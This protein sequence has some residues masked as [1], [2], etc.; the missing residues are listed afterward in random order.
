MLLT[1][2]ASVFQAHSAQL[3]QSAHNN[4]DA[5]YF[6][7]RL[8]RAVSNVKK[9]TSTSVII[10][11]NRKLRGLFAERLDTQTDPRKQTRPK[12]DSDPTHLQ[13]QRVFLY[14][15]PVVWLLA[16]ASEIFVSFCA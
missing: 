16:F 15:F 1:A 13:L 11:L 9:K 4:S 2:S 5:T 12:K 14:P 3:P 8:S 10:L 7:E 6:F